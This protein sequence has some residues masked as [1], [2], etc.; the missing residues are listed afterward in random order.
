MPSLH[1]LVIKTLQPTAL[2]AFYT[3]LGFEFD[4]INTA[5]ALFTTPAG[6]RP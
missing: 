4:H 6:E 5:K 1:L 2:A 3:I